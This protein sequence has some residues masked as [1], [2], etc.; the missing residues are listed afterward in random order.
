MFE[1]TYVPAFLFTV[2]G[3]ILKE[4]TLVGVGEKT[5]CKAAMRVPLLSPAFPQPSLCPIARASWLGGH[6]SLIVV[7][8][9][10]ELT[11]GE[12]QD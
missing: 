3:E 7:S 1:D 8:A 12:G 11:H 9:L 2:Q 4:E 5:V 10:Q 6:L